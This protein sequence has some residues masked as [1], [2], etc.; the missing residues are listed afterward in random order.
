MGKTK[1]LTAFEVKFPKKRTS[2]QNLPDP[3]IPTH[4]FFIFFV[5]KRTNTNNVAKL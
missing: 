2:V 5:N 1:K 3:T 4:F